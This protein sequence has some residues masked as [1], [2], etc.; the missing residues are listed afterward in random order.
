MTLVNAAGGLIDGNSATVGL[1]IDTGAATVT[2]AGI[3]ENTGAAGT[4]INSA[5]NN[6]GTLSV[7]AGTLVVA[8]AVGGAGAVRI[9]G[10]TADFAS[11]FSENVAFT[12]TAGVL[13]LANSTTYTGKISGFSHAGTTSLDLLDIG[14]TSGVTTASFSGTTTAGTLTVTDG[15]NTAE[16][17]LIGNYTTSTFTVSSDGHGGTTVVDPTKPV[18]THIIQPIQPLVAAM[19]GFGAHG[20]A[21]TAAVE[22][23]RGS[24][25]FWRCRGLISPKIAAGMELAGWA[26]EFLKAG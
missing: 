2:N 19:A 17:S 8:G 18:G 7:F 9:A 3:I 26:T 6:T 12:G 23:W 10:G 5:V 13:V 15:T 20:A 22:A 14:F 1:T 25:Q 11:T 4:T 21:V 16:I 24:S